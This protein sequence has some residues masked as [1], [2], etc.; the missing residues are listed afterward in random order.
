MIY[1][2]AGMGIG[3]VL[4]ALGARRR[5]GR[6]PDLLQWAAVGALIGGILGLFLMI[7]LDRSLSA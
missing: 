5:D 3:A 6:L 7:G 4:G 1:P 2:L